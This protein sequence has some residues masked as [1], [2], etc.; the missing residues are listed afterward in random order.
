VDDEFLPLLGKRYVAG[1]YYG[2]GSPAALPPR[3]VVRKLL[4]RGVTR[5]RRVPPYHPHPYSSERNLPY[6]SSIA[7]HRG[8][9][10]C[11]LCVALL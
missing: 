11:L 3:L 4:P 5:A 2:L 9:V 10:C 8:A 6:C 7:L 1:H